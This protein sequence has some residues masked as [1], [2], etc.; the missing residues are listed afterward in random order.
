[1]TFRHTH[2]RKRNSEFR[3]SVCVLQVHQL[4]FASPYQPLDVE[5]VGALGAGGVLSERCSHTLSSRERLPVAGPQERAVQPEH[6]SL[7]LRALH[8]SE[9]RPLCHA[10]LVY[11]VRTM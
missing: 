6:L 11:T 8:V 7:K 5:Y 2:T 10:H 9:P 3:Y 1:M 4:P